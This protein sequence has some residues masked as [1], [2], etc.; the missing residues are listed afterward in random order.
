MK[1]AFPFRM[2]DR[3]LERGDDRCT[4]VKTLTGGEELPGPGSGMGRYPWSLIVEAMVQAG[5]PLASRAGDGIGESAPEPTAVAGAL[6]AIHSAR[7]HAPVGPGDVLRITATITAR[8]GGMIRLS[9][10]AE[11]QGRSGVVAEGEF[12]LATSPATGEA[13]DAG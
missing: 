1:H 8:W 2:I 10:R 13:G 9:S 3:V 7:L 11:V 6:V 12:T 5:L 4:I